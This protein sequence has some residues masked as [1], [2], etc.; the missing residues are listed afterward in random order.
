MSE[1]KKEQLQETT[2]AL[3]SYTE[4]QKFD[5]KVEICYY[6]YVNQMKGSLD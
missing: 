5:K 4:S 2:E 6:N 3:N 1:E